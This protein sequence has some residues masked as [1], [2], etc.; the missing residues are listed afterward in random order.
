M[1]NQSDCVTR[2]T[3]A[4]LSGRMLVG[5]K[6]KKNWYKSAYLYMVLNTHCEICW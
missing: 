5:V 1:A 6:K 2:Q 3:S 4:C